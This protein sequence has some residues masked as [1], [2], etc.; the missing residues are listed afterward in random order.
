MIGGQTGDMMIIAPFRPR[1]GGT[2]DVVDGSY[3]GYRPG[4]SDYVSLPTLHFS[5]F[6]GDSAGPMQCL[7][8]TSS[9]SCHTQSRF[10]S[11]EQQ[12][13]FCEAYLAELEGATPSGA[14]VE[15]LLAEAGQVIKG[16]T[17]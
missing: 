3:N 8:F 1:I 10:P 6:R 4:L 15:A 11:P 2:D 9:S 14:A 13:V 7:S 12:R 5:A 17:G 16:S